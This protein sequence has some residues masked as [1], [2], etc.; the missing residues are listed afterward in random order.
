MPAGASR[1]AAVPS[2]STPLKPPPPYISA[3]WFQ[4]VGRLS[5]KRM[6]SA[7]VVRAAMLPCSWQYSGSSPAAGT[8][9]AAVT[10]AAPLGRPMRVGATVVPAMRVQA[11]CNSAT[12]GTGGG[13]SLSL[14]QAHRVSSRAEAATA[15]GKAVGMRLGYIGVSGGTAPATWCAFVMSRHAQNCM[16]VQC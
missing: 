12:P 3:F 5:W 6:G 15:R 8:S 10:V 1:S 4:V 14:P 2:I 11:C 16:F 13:A 7:P 9:T